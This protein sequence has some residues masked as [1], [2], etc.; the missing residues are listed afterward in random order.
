M[1]YSNQF[2]QY[3]LDAERRIAMPPLRPVMRWAGGKSAMIGKLAGLLPSRWNRYIEP[4]SGGAAL[5]FNVRPSQAILADVNSDLINF[6]TVLRDR[7]ADLTRRLLSMR[8]S[9][10]HYY[11]L[12]SSR[13]RTDIN[14]A[15]RFAYLNRLAWNGLYRVNRR[16]EFNVPIGDRLPVTMWDE[17]DLLNASA[18]LAG[19]QLI[20]GDFRTTVQEARAGDFVFLDP[21]YPRGSKERVG[22]NRYASEFFAMA[23]HQDL[24]ALIEKMTKCS[25][26]VMLT[27]PRKDHFATIYPSSLR[28]TTVRSKALIACNGPD[29]KHVAELILTNY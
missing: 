23:D 13:P 15:V 22:F 2:V 19:V 12:R 3:S 14:R 21:P 17:R 20:A 26:Q 7:P 6:Y 29:R 9:R 18:A 5:Y 11:D 27:L 8:A 10:D 1:I 4:M 24:A 25:V 16:G 28:R